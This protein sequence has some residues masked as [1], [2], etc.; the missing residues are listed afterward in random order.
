MNNNNFKLFSRET[1][2]SFLSAFLSSLL[3]KKD[4]FSHITN[5]TKLDEGY[6]DEFNF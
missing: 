6:I 2:P 4:Y 3:I 5:D 1:N